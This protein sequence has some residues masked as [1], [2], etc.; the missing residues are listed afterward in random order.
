[1]FEGDDLDAEDQKPVISEPG[2]DVYPDQPSLMRALKI[3][4]FGPFYY[5][6]KSWKGSLSLIAFIF[7]LTILTQVGGVILW[8]SLPLVDRIC[9]ANVIKR[10]MAKIMLFVACY[11]LG[12]LLITPFLASK[13]GRVQLPYRATSKTALRPANMG[14]F[15]LC[16]NYVRP[17]VR[18]ELERIALEISKRDQGTTLVY[19]DANFPFFDGFPLLP[20]LNHD[21]GK[22]VDIAFLYRST[23]TRKPLHITPSPIGYWAYE[24]PMPH[25][26]Q[27]CSE[28]QSWL[29]WDLDWLQPA[30]GYAE[31]DPERTQFLLNSFIASPN[32]EKI[33]V[34]PHIKER[35]KISSEKVR[36]QG[37]HAARH[38]DHIHLQ[39]Q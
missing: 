19:L 22:M 9:I 29:R 2:P 34:E 18:D 3:F 16:R 13:L 27:P 15:L 17:A 33:L 36:F 35:L 5:F 11:L 8:I 38:D 37:C 24:Q 23:S 32:I 12:I 26:P 4:T 21:S 1:M 30:F 20:H 6:K 7:I 25:E 31:L 28:R 14:F 39:F 10:R